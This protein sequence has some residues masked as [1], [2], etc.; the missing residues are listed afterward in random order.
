M[1]N[2][3]RKVKVHALER[4][5]KVDIEAISDTA[6]NASD[7]YIG[8]TLGATGILD[9]PTVSVDN[10]TEK[11]SITDCTW[12][13][14]QTHHEAL[15]GAYSG[16]LG[17][18]KAN[19]SR[20]GDIDFDAVRASVQAYY[21]VHSALP[22]LPTDELNYVPATHGFAYPYV[23]A[24]TSMVDSEISSRRFWSTNDAT[25]TT[26]NVATEQ[27]QV[28]QFSLVSRED[29][30]PIGGD[31]PA[32]KIL[33]IVGWTVSANVV[34]LLT[35]IPVRAGDGVLGLYPYHLDI[36]GGTS[37]SGGNNVGLASVLYWMKQRQDAMVEGGTSDPAGTVDVGNER[38]P[39]Y[40]LAGLEKWLGD[41]VTA[42]EDRVLRA[43][44]IVKSRVNVPTN[45]NEC[46]IHP[47]TGNDF[48]VLAYRDYGFLYDIT[49]TGGT[50][51]GAGTEASDLAGMNDIER[52]VGA[53]H[54]NIPSTYAGYGMQ[55]SLT[56]IF[57]SHDFRWLK[58]DDPDGGSLVTIGDKN[59]FDAPWVLN[60]S[61]GHTE[62]GNITAWANQMNT[63]S[64]GTGL[65]QDA[66]SFSTPAQYGFSIAHPMAYNGSTPASLHNNVVITNTAYATLYVKVDITLMKP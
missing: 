35:V 38:G 3:S 21:N 56:T 66:T 9:A 43:S 52:M 60:P 59:L 4:L 61:V 44:C 58:A 41:R 53:V 50:L 25:E 29:A 24:T 22:P 6:H 16:F 39:R 17:Y 62:F 5:D 1:A 14:I 10:G 63:V 34:N 64:L 46:T 27:Q 31:F 8:A 49:A 12:F 45:T 11:I 47:F 36:N 51:F 65:K 26:D 19:D 48:T 33:R 20:H 15:S 55:V 32:V 2:A 18:Y 54:I 7:N 42:V 37:F 57:P 13:G 28:H 40:S 23:Y 30:P